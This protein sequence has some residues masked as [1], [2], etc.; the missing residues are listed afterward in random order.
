M[1][2]T[3]REGRA[4]LNM[5]VVV[6]TELILQVLHMLPPEDSP[7]KERLNGIFFVLVAALAF[8]MAATVK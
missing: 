7:G 1:S 6:M 2:R 4:S 3:P 8:V 5:A